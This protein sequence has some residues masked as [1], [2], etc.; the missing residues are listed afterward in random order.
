MHLR[1]DLAVKRAEL[2]EHL[3]RIYR[4]LDELMS[5]DRR[6]IDA[7]PSVPIPLAELEQY[8]KNFEERQGL[9][10]ELFELSSVPIEDI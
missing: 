1:G 8:G 6:I 7:N 2:Q 3:G 4:R 9:H 5:F 10:Q